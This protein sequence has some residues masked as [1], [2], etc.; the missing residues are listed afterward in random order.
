MKTEQFGIVLKRIMVDSTIAPEA[1]AIYSYLAT[2]SNE[3]GKSYPSIDK[4][5]RDLGMTYNRLTKYRK[6][7]EEAGYLKVER[8]R[9]E[10]GGFGRNVYTIPTRTYKKAER[11]EPSQ[12]PFVD[13][14]GMEDRGYNKDQS[15]NIKTNKTNVQQDDVDVVVY[16]MSEMLEK[17]QLGK[18][19]ESWREEILLWLQT[20]QP[21]MIRY[22]MEWSVQHHAKSWLYVRAVLRAWQEKKLW[23]VEDVV[24]YEKKRVQRPTIIRR[25]EALPDWFVNHS[26]VAETP[27]ESEEEL[28]ARRQRLKEKWGIEV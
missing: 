13:F 16:E 4:M 14:E 9:S 2:F 6:Q 17:Y 20:F 12:N 21:Q 23:T 19:T 15:N 18:A 3:E 5:C 1:K 28:E 7:L 24:A 25:T 22:A 11:K 10:Q 26:S 27:T 8:T